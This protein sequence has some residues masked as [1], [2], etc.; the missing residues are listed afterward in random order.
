MGISVSGILGSILGSVASGFVGKLFGGDDKGRP[1]PSVSVPVDQKE[2]L[3]KGL[4]KAVQAQ[5]RA[6]RRRAT[7]VGRKKT[8]L[9]SPLGLADDK[10]IAR[11]SLLGQ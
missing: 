5:D 7:V 2:E 3:I 10:N 6:R 4:D 1:I 9:T 11:P 8:I